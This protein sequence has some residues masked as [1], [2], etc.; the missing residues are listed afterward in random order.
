MRQMRKLIATLFGALVLAASSHATPYTQF[1]VFGD[2]LSDPGNALATTGGLFPPTPPYAASFS[3]GPTAAQYLAQSLG[4]T[5]QLGWP[6]ASAASNN[7]AFGGARNGIGN[8]NFEIGSVPLPVIAETGIQRQIER[9]GAVNPVVA[10]P[11]AT[12]FM[13]WGGANDMFLGA[14]TFSNP[15]LYIPGALLAL[16]SDLL[17]LAGMGA[18]HILVPGMPDLGR[19]P[20][21]FAQ[22]P[23]AAAGLSAISAAYNANLDALLAGL[24]LGLSGLGVHV[25]EFD[26]AAFFANITATPAAFGFTNAT[27]SCLFSL[28]PAA[29]CAGYLY[30][31][32]VHPT[33]AAHQLLAQQFAAAAGVPEPGTLSLLL[34]ALA[35]LGSLARRRSLDDRR[36]RARELTVT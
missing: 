27:D 25:Y 6:G 7:F 8:Y 32:R 14:E 34:L 19:T 10:D 2:S 13:V 23:A 16:Q 28:G 15:A 31:D 9:Y 3:N 29:D 26:T 30:Y 35:P 33:T 22:G 1:I 17:T 5:V 21:A 36:A 4:V 18:K 24:S 12:L 11:A 20:E